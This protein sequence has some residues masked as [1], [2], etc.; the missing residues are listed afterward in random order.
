MS[1]IVNAENFILCQNCYENAFTKI[2]TLP[3]IY[4]VS[5]QSSYF[6]TKNKYVEVRW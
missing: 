3:V 1:L 5:S 2:E 4:N 6:C